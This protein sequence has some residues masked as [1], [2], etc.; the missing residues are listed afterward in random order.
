M[1][2]LKVSYSASLMGE[3]LSLFLS[4]PGIPP[5]AVLRSPGRFPKHNAI[6]EL[7]DGF[8]WGMKEDVPPNS[9]TAAEREAI[10]DLIRAKSDREI[11]RLLRKSYRLLNLHR[12]RRSTVSHRERWN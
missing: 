8:T 4:C 7:K 3:E 10:R 2:G 11:A 5:C 6:L 12:R 1:S 9:E